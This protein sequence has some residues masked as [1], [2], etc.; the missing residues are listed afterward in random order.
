MPPRK[1]R[2]FVMGFDS[3]SD[4]SLPEDDLDTSIKGKG[5]AKAKSGDKLRSDKGK[6]KA[7]DAVSWIDVQWH[8]YKLRTIFSKHTHGKRRIR[9]LGTRFKK[10]KQAVYNLPLRN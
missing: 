10:T 8:S 2:D 7:K 6:G 1:D 5:K 3:D 4:I 9:V